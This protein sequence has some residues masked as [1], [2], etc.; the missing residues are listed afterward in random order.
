VVS[1]RSGA[2]RVFGFA[3]GDRVC[4]LAS[5]A[6][7]AIRNKVKSKKGKVTAH[8]AATAGIVNDARSYPGGVHST[9]AATAARQSV[10]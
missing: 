4:A 7:G 8:S 2:V 9:L 3:V 6:K 1:F 10:K 5:A